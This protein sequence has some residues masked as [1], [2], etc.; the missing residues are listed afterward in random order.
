M[1]TLILSTIGSIFLGPVGTVLG[2]VAGNAIDHAIIGGKS[3]TREG[4]RLTDLTVQSAAYGEVIPLLYGGVRVAGNLIWSTGLIERRN[5]QHQG[6]KG[7]STTTTTYS[8]T[9]SF[10]VGLAGRPITDIGRIWADGK[11]IRSTG[12]PL[13]P[14]GKFRLYL[15]SQVQNPDALLQA[16]LGLDRAPAHRGLAYAVF[17]E[18]PLADFGNRIPNLT[19]EVIAD[20][21]SMV[22]VRNL[23]DDLIA[24][25][26][27]PRRAVSGPDG[28]LLGFVVAQDVA[29]RTLIETI[30][31]IAPLV[32]DA[33][34][35]MLSVRG[36]AMTASR[37]LPSAQY[38]AAEAT[39]QS[40]IAVRR[41]RAP[42]ESLPR[43]LQLRH[44]DPARDYQT[45]IQRA[46][47]R[48]GG[49][50]KRQTLDVPAVL[51]ATD[52]KKLAETSLAR[53][54]RE[55]DRLE[56]R[57]SQS[58][59]DL[60]PGDTVALDD[61]PSALFTI[62]SLGVEEGGMTIGL[63][64]LNSADTLSLAAADSGVQI[65]QAS[66][67][68]G[69]T[70]LEVLDLPPIE[71]AL[72]RTGRV[73]LAATGALTGWRR[74]AIWW[75][76]NGGASYEQN[77]IVTR[78]N[79]LGHTL[80]ILP[81]GVTGLWD[82]V[83][84]VDVALVSP[85][86]TLNSQ[87]QAAVLAGANLAVIG[88]ELVAFKYALDLGGGHYRLSGLLRGVRGTEATLTSHSLSE[89]FVLLSPL[90]D[91]SFDVPLSNSGTSQQWKALSPG[92]GLGDVAAQSVLFQARALRPLSPV[93]LTSST[94]T[95]GDLTLSWIRRS[96]DGFSWLDGTDVPLAEESERYRLTVRNA[97]GTKRTLDITTTGW[98][99]ARADQL[100]DGLTT[101]TGV[102]I[103]VAQLSASVGP[104]NTATLS[105]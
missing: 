74:C 86:A 102:S 100:A 26:S 24:R 12:G 56:I 84:S 101:L 82:E 63:R 33:R 45:G 50:F 44:L 75:S 41:D 103:D 11:L 40:K 72:P 70:S 96:R 10:A 79:V 89:R 48:D 68:H 4:P 77:A 59:A 35:G 39:R 27:V 53:A 34:D 16:A 21:G 105:F 1:A 83:S 64:P 2:A 60:R 36:P 52:A 37:T 15:G 55:R 25:S 30:S 18:L 61:S 81:P 38:G 19:F 28:V 6:G 62:A 93:R 98:T 66:N 9:S 76:Q 7:G 51:S 104:G 88:N 3:T 43:E 46:R 92:E 42:A 65:A 97:S 90:P 95:S 13:T 91:A 67:V 8:Y 32:T 22:A 17:E 71:A 80:S 85:T 94:A 99:Y 31:G 57:L 87:S 69:P 47:R 73:L 29:A 20:D 23:I 49:Y 54:W 58:F 14:G 5:V 78:P